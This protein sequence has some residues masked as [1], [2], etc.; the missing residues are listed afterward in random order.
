MAVPGVP[1]LITFE[2][3]SATVFKIINKLTDKQK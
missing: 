2:N 1:R 3:I